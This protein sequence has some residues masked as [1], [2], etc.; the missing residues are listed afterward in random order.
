MTIFFIVPELACLA[1]LASKNE[2]NFVK[3]FFGRMTFSL[4]NEDITE[5]LMGKFIEN[6]HHVLQNTHDFLNFVQFKDNLECKGPRLNKNDV[7]SSLLP[8]AIVEMKISFCID[9]GALQMKER[10]K[11]NQE[12]ECRRNV[13][14]RS[15]LFEI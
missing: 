7:E 8:Q 3:F 10:G 5:I 4:K 1:C 11:C 13:V 6:T 9:R 15:F 2:Q 14:T 12:P